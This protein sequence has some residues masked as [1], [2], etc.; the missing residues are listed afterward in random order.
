MAVDWHKYLGVSHLFLFFEALIIWIAGVLACAELS[1]TL[2]LDV[3]RTDGS[4]KVYLI[5][6]LVTGVVLGLLQTYYIFIRVCK[7]NLDRI[8]ELEKPLFF[9]C[10]RIY[11]YVFFGTFDTAMVLISNEYVVTKTAKVIMGALDMSVAIG[12]TLSLYTYVEYWKLFMKRRNDLASTDGLE[13][14]RKSPFIQPSV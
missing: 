12:L 7:R 3:Y 13:D 9:N 11:F 8:L 14:D 2:L 10:F 5:V 4:D 1:S 6:G